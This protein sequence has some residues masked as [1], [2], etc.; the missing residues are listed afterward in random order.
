MYYNPV[1]IIETDNWRKECLKQLGALKVTNPAIVTS[2]GNLK[3]QEL[4]GIFPFS[5]IFSEVN[6]IP[7]LEICQSAI[8]FVQNSRFD[9]VVA[10]GGGSVMD[11][12]KVMI[13]ALGT[14]VN[15]I[16]QLLRFQLVFQCKIS[17]IFIP[18][19]H[20]SGSE[21]TMWSTIWDLNLKKKYSLECP[22][23]YPSIAIL[24]G[25][26]T[27]SLP[28]DISLIAVLDSLSHSF[29]AIWNKNANVQSTI[30]AIEAI[31]LILNN[32]K[33]LKN[34][35]N[36]IKLRNSLLKA[37]NVAGRAFSN[38]K[39]AAA[40]A[41]S[42]PLTA[43]FNIPHGIA[44]SLALLPLL[45]INKL[46]IEDEI[47]QI[48]S[49]LNLGKFSEFENRILDISSGLIKYSLKDWGV[50]FSQIPEI[51]IQAHAEGRIRNNIIELSQREVIKILELIFDFN[52]S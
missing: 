49:A 52:K 11:V 19:T 15:S 6:S 10:I 44:A 37:S 35:L 23:L 3:R 13:A 26:L 31:S 21:V 25:S 5:S 43:N 14:K 34:N 41:I 42:Y 36:N 30:F 47:N 39:T 18:T 38:T 40:H 16:Q 2:N 33:E 50:K 20:G 51:A 32:V 9:G 1:K 29:E 27:L 28:L 46:A 17:G 7:S 8:N 24:D 22:D 45:R 12:A 4:G 48:I